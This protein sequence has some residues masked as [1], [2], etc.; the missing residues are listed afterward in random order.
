M[1]YE[2]ALS[3]SE[4][5]VEAYD[6]ARLEVLPGVGHGFYGNDAEQAVTWILEYLN[7]HINFN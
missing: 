2:D 4:K 6:S 7:T 1:N 5:A 3:Y